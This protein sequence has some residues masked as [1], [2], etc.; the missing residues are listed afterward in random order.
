MKHASMPVDYNIRIMIHGTPEET[1][2]LVGPLGHMT[3]I[4]CSEVCDEI[5]RY[6]VIELCSQPD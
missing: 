1:K 2:G 4:T 5:L 6:Y 3:M